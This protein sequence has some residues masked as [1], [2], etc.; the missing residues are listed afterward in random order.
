MEKEYSYTVLGMLIGT[1]IGG[2]IT[3]P[4]FSITGNPLFIAFFGLGTAFGRHIIN[5]RMGTLIKRLTCY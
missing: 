4:L 2:A 1:A 3:V 5:W